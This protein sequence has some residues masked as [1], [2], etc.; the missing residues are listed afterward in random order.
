ML[1]TCGWGGAALDPLLGQALLPVRHQHLAAPW[2][3]PPSAGSAQRG[4]LFWQAHGGWLVLGG[5]RWATPH[6]EVWETEDR[7]T[8]TAVQQRLGALRERAFPGA[9]PPT[10]AWSAILTHTCD[11]LPLI[12]P[13]PGRPRRAAAVGFREHGAALGLEAGRC[14]AQGVL[15]GRAPALPGWLSPGRL[16]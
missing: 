14:L 16:L 13:L 8:S 11:N 5:A 15:E 3:G 4:Y 6:L 9:G 7:T 12:G 2:A 1:L 10:A